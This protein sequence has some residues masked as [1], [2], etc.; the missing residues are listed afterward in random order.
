MN[1]IVLDFPSDLD[2]EQKRLFKHLG[3][4]G[5]GLSVDRSHASSL[6]Q[7]LNTFFNSSSVNLDVRKDVKDIIVALAHGATH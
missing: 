4:Q 7:Y 2:K 1:R 6:L 5:V 3:E